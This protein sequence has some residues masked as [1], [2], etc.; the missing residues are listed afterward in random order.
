M[1][2]LLSRRLAASGRQAVGLPLVGLLLSLQLLAGCGG[3]SPFAEPTATPIPTATPTPLP[4]PTLAPGATP[5]PTPQVTIPQGFTVVQDARLRYSFAVPSGWSEL[6][7]RGGQ[8]QTMAGLLGMGEQLTQLNE[9]LASPEGQ[10]FGKLYIA[11]L[12]SVMFGGLPSLLN[13]SVV[14]APGI[15]AEGAASQVQQVI[16]QNMS[17]LGG[18][19]TIGAVEALTI[20]NLPAV[21]STAT[22]NLAAVGIDNSIF[23]KVVGLLANDQI[24]VMTLITPLDQRTAKEPTFDQIIGAFRPE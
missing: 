17:A 22:A 2:S 21:R 13:V 11:D 23:A 16:E 19:V 9:F 4:T 14:A 8:V 18:D 6:D 15:S 1:L 3:A 24:Y 5:A 20:N 7:L 10:L 12:T